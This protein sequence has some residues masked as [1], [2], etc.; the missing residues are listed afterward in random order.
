MTP[1]PNSY[2]V[3]A[4]RVEPRDS[5]DDFPT[6]PWAVRALMEYI[7]DPDRLDVLTD[8]RSCL[9]PACNRG[10]MSRTLS[11]YFKSVT[12]SDVADYGFGTVRDFLEEPYPALSFDWVITNPPFRLA[13]KFV[14]EALDVASEGVAVF[15]RT[16]FLE[17]VGRYNRLFKEARPTFVFPF[18]ERVPLVKGRVDPNATTATAYM[19][20]VWMKQRVPYD[21][22][23]PFNLDWIAPCRKELESP[24]DYELPEPLWASNLPEGQP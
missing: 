13:E 22:I 12:S 21:L 2:A 5:L 7:I 23:W 20:I 9:E 8:E 15:V 14:R 16:Q 3:R 18:S 17:G 19:W 11:E 6:P 24:G 4:Q 1:T 10:F